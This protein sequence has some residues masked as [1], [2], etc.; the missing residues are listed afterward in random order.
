MTKFGSIYLH[1]NQLKVNIIC[2]RNFA[3]VVHNTQDKRLCMNGHV[4]RI[5]TNS[6][7]QKYGLAIARG[8][9]EGRKKLD[10]TRTFEAVK[11]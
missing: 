2:S 8:F 11:G 4:K 7:P 10:S 5:E 3:K 9:F 1:C 6:L